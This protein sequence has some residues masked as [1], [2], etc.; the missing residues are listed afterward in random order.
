MILK[1]ADYHVVDQCIS[2]LFTSASGWLLTSASAGSSVT[3]G[4]HTLPREYSLQ[5]PELTVYM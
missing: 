4:A 2:W 3:P 1:H 5:T